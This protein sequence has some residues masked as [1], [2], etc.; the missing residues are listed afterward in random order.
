MSIEKIMRLWELLSLAAPHIL[1]FFNT[2][3]KIPGGVEWTIT[4]LVFGVGLITVLILAI[5]KYFKGTIL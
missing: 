3:I 5:W 4:E 2:T 1:D